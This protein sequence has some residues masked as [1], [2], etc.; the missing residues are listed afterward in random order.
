MGQ[1]GWGG[2]GAEIGKRLFLEG[3][4]HLQG[5]RGPGD[6]KPR[7]EADPDPVPP[8]PTGHQQCLG[9]PGAGGEG[10]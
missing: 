5:S 7:P 4:G 6:L 2:Y 8:I 3:M 1:P 10:L 9:L